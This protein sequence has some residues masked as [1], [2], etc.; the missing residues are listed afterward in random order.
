MTADSSHRRV[1]QEP[2]SS[3]GRDAALTLQAV[4]E[5]LKTTPSSTRFLTIQ[6]A[7]RPNDRISCKI[8][9]TPFGE[10][11]AFKALSYQWGNEAATEC[12]VL[13][14]VECPVKQNL[15]D[16]L[17]YLRRKWPAERFWIDA[18]CINQADNNERS[19]QVRLMRTIFFR[20]SA[21][22]VWLGKDYE[23]YAPE[24]PQLQRLGHGSM[25]KATSGAEAAMP[26]TTPT[27]A[28]ATKAANEDDVSSLPLAKDLYQNGYWNRV[29][30]VQEVGL[31]AELIVCFGDY[32]INWGGF[33][34][35][36]TMHHVGNE[37]P[38]KLHEQRRRRY[39][40]SCK[41]IQLLHDY[42][43]AQC[44]DPKD[45]VYGLIGL[46]AD[47]RFFPIDYNKS[48]FEIWR[49]VMEFANQGK[50]LANDEIISTGSLVKY[51]L[52]GAGCEPLDQILRSYAPAEEAAALVNQ[53]NSPKVFQVPAKALGCV[54]YIGPPPN[55]IVNDPMKQELWEAVVQACNTDDAGSA[56]AESD[57]L[58]RK[59]VMPGG[60]DLNGTC[61]TYSSVVQWSAGSHM[62][63]G[64][65]SYH[66][67][68]V[69]KWQA[70]IEAPQYSS[71]S[72]KVQE[73]LTEG[74]R[75]YQLD[76]FF[77][78][79]DWKMGVASSQVRLGDLI[80][81]VASSRM[82]IILRPQYNDRS[83][84]WTLQAVGTAAVAKDLQGISPE[85]HRRRYKNFPQS[86]GYSDT[87]ASLTVHL[88]ATFLFILLESERIFKEL[89]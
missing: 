89:D 57:M 43:D 17:H 70:K 51:L 64:L 16:A 42:K 84:R 28:E 27:E 69:E 62:G 25:S 7:N 80:C 46:A 79:K 30:I 8:S 32:A 63:G 50:M 5:P 18:L 26:N 61:F 34:H 60:P 88:D 9:E 19:A 15:L 35:L 1:D 75:L 6:P 14:G 36:L 48:R 59:M 40:G 22:I 54:R 10:L 82:A 74:V 49:H 11:P 83:N 31:A 71:G 47:A 4:Y 23:K 67:Q 13:N 76:S 45:K 77:R 41:L 86:R 85:A 66:G 29:W 24:L 78:S 87:S 53:P 20:A 68:A 55:E 56:H 2:A 33:I 73:S 44:H 12:I 39:E 81:W 52:M 38:L 21:V 58:L 3:D 37:G 72:E 65:E